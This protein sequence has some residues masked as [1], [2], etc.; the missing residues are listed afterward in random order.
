MANICLKIR[1]IKS[2]T[3]INKAHK[4][5]NPIE[6]T[7]LIDPFQDSRKRFS[8]EVSKRIQMLRE[9]K[10]LDRKFSKNEIE[11][12]EIVFTASPEWFRKKIDLPQGWRDFNDEQKTKLWA[13]HKPDPEQVEK[14]KKTTLEM[15]REQFP[16]EAIVNVALHD[17][18]EL[19]P[20]IHCLILPMT[21][22]EGGKPSR[23]SY[24]KIFGQAKGRKEQNGFEAWQDKAGEYFG[25]IGLER[26]QRGS[27]SVYK[28]PREWN[29]ETA[30]ARQQAQK[31]ADLITTLLK[32]KALI[33]RYGGRHKSVFNSADENRKIAQ[34]QKLIS[35]GLSSERLAGE[36]STRHYNTA[37]KAYIE[38]NANEHLKAEKKRATEQ[39]AR[40]KTDEQFLSMFEKAKKAN[41]EE[42]EEALQKLL[43]LSTPAKRP[44]LVVSPGPDLKIL[45][46]PPARIQT[47]L[48]PTQSTQS[49]F[50][51]ETSESV[52]YDLIGEA[53]PQ[54]SKAFDKMTAGEKMTYF[55]LRKAWEERENARRERLKKGKP[56]PK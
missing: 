56:K 15:L 21:K 26:G 27:L 48:E 17:K 34:A 10:Q 1:A 9:S 19:S 11:L 53:E 5:N 55:K 36:I 25:K 41:P 4:H 2:R 22:P 23:L 12:A 49:E 50:I 8:Q 37:K 20:H 47:T 42:A 43:K 24:D 18:H 44:Q 13:K 30:E 51:Q 6:A 40:R 45:S 32:R 54:P 28:P 38:R 52:N 31:E 39:S 46:R 16:A 14:F 35:E 3:E 33:D 29:A 7:K